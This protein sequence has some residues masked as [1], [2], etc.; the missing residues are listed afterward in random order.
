[1]HT[2]PNFTTL[3]NIFFLNYPMVLTNFI[4]F[5]F[6]VGSGQM[7]SD[8]LSKVAEVVTDDEWK[9][10]NDEETILGVEHA[11]L[12]MTLKKLIQ[13]DKEA[14]KNGCP[15]FSEALVHYLTDDVVC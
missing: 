7:L 2:H 6:N 15:T 11:G 13:N 14:I 1:M 12:H 10:K 8:T 4:I 5:Q 3:S 9:I